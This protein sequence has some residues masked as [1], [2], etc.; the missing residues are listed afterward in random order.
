[1][2]GK[3]IEMLGDYVLI[4][5]KKPESMTKGGILLPDT[6]KEGDP[7]SFG[8]VIA[9]GPGRV[10]MGHLIPR[11]VS[12]GDCVVYH[13]GYKEATMNWMGEEVVILKET[14]VVAVVRN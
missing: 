4:K 1:M 7:V 14:D 10:E 13:S 6:V 8:E 3:S 11:T 2:T 12:K 9:C 5:H